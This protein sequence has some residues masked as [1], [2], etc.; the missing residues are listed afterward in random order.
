MD[1]EQKTFDPSKH[2]KTLKEGGQEYLEV[3]WRLVWL[4][5][6]H[7]DAVI[8]TERIGFDSLFAC[9]KAH[10]SIPGGGSATG[11]GMETQDKFGDYMEKAETK[12]L[13]RAL[14]AL[15]YGTQFCEEF[16]SDG[17]VVDSPVQRPAA[18]ATAPVTAHRPAPAE[19]PRGFCPDHPTRPFVERKSKDGGTWWACGTKIGRQD[20]K[21]LWCPLRP[22][23]TTPAKAPAR[24]PAATAKVVETSARTAPPFVP[25]NIGAVFMR[26]WSELQMPRQDVLKALGVPEPTDWAGTPAEAWAKVLACKEALRHEQVP[27]DTDP[28][29]G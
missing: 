20:N 1:A 5:S 8:E 9:F 19:A 28:K 26:A 6:E 16:E 25:T 14:A 7:P 17:S 24:A 4:R 21:D 10:V 2:L 11:W 18:P 23:D 29:E 22:H 3:K 12:A 13:G 27:L 15:G